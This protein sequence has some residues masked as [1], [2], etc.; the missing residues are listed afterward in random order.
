MSASEKKNGEMSFEDI[1]RRA[2]VTVLAAVKNSGVI[3]S[4]SLKVLIVTTGLLHVYK[5]ESKHDG[6]PKRYLITDE[7]VLTVFNCC[8]ESKNRHKLLIHGPNNYKLDIIFDNAY[9]QGRLIEALLG[10]GARINDPNSNLIY[11]EYLST[12]GATGGDDQLNLGKLTKPAKSNQ[13]LNETADKSSLKAISTQS[14][15]RTDNAY[16]VVVFGSA[17]FVENCSVSKEAR[18]N[19]MSSLDAL[20][21]TTFIDSLEDVGNQDEGIYSTTVRIDDW[22]GRLDRIESENPKVQG[23]VNDGDLNAEGKLT[24]KNI[25]HVDVTLPNVREGKVVEVDESLNG[26]SFESNDQG[27]IPH[28]E[29]N[30]GNDPVST[31]DVQKRGNEQGQECEYE[32][33]VADSNVDLSTGEEATQRKT[34]EMKAGEAGNDIGGVQETEYE[35]KD[36]GIYEQLW[37]SSTSSQPE[38]QI[39]NLSGVADEVCSGTMVCHDGILIDQQRQENDILRETGHSV[40]LANSNVVIEP[41]QHI[42]SEESTTQ[43]T[44][45][46]VNN[47]DLQKIGEAPENGHIIS[48]SGMHVQLFQHSN[49]VH[50]EQISDETFCSERK[51]QENDAQS[52]GLG[53]DALGTG[54]ISKVEFPQINFASHNDENIYETFQ[55]TPSNVGNSFADHVHSADDYVRENELEISDEKEKERENLDKNVKNGTEF[56]Q[57]ENP[58]EC[59]ATTNGIKS[60]SPN[61]EVDGV[62]NT[63]D[64]EVYSVLNHDCSSPKTSL[65]DSA[66]S[67]SGVQPCESAFCNSDKC[68]LLENKSLSNSKAATADDAA[69][70]SNDPILVNN[71]SLEEIIRPIKTLDQNRSSIVVIGIIEPKDSTDAESIYSDIKFMQSRAA[72]KAAAWNYDGRLNTEPIMPPEVNADLHSSNDSS[73]YKAG[74]IDAPPT[75]IEGISNLGENFVERSLELDLD[76][77]ISE[78]EHADL[79]S[80][81][82]KD[83]ALAQER[84]ITLETGSLEVADRDSS[85]SK[86]NQTTPSNNVTD[87]RRNT[88]EEGEK[89]G[90]TLN[91]ENHEIKAFTVAA[92]INDDVQSNLPHL[93]T[94]NPSDQLITTETIGETKQQASEASNSHLT[95]QAE[96]TVHQK[97]GNAEIFSSQSIYTLD[98]MEVETST[99]NASKR[100]EANAEIETNSRRYSTDLIDT[101]T[102][103][104]TE[105]F[106]SEMSPVITDVSVERVDSRSQSHEDEVSSLISNRAESQ[107]DLKTLHGLEDSGMETSTASSVNKSE[108]EFNKPAYALTGRNYREGNTFDNNNPSDKVFDLETCP[109]E[110]YYM[111]AGENKAAEEVGDLFIKIKNRIDDDDFINDEEWQTENEEEAFRGADASNASLIDVSGG[112]MQEETIGASDSSRTSGEKLSFEQ[113]MGKTLSSKKVRFNDDVQERLYAIS[114]DEGES[115]S[116]TDCEDEKPSEYLHQADIN[117]DDSVDNLYELN[118]SASESND[119]VQNDKDEY[120]D[121]EDSGESLSGPEELPVEIQD[122]ESSHNGIDIHKR[123]EKSCP[124]FAPSRIPTAIRTLNY[125]LRERRSLETKMK[126]ERNKASSEKSIIEQNLPNDLPIVNLHPEAQTSSNSQLSTVHCE[127]SG[128]CMVDVTGNGTKFFKRLI[129][130]D[131]GFL[132]VLPAKEHLQSDSELQ[133]SL[134][135]PNATSYRQQVVLDKISLKGASVQPGLHPSSSGLFNIVLQPALH[136]RINIQVPTRDEQMR[137]TLLLS[138]EVVR[139]TPEPERPKL[140]YPSKPTKLQPDV[141]KTPGPEDLIHKEESPSS[142]SRDTSD[143]ELCIPPDEFAVRELDFN[144]NRPLVLGTNSSTEQAIEGSEGNHCKRISIKEFALDSN[145]STT[146]LNSRVLKNSHTESNDT[147]S[148]SSVRSHETLQFDSLAPSLETE[149]SSQERPST[150][151]Q[152][153]PSFS[154]HFVVQQEEKY[155][156]KGFEYSSLKLKKNKQKAAVKKSNNGRDHSLTDAGKASK[157]RI[158]SF[159]GSKTSNSITDSKPQPTADRVHRNNSSRNSP[160]FGHVSAMKNIFENISTN[161]N[162][163][164]NT[165]HQ[166]KASLESSCKDSMA[167]SEAAHPAASPLSSALSHVPSKESTLNATAPQQREAGIRPSACAPATDASTLT[168]HNS[169]EVELNKEAVES[170]NQVKREVM[171]MKVAVAALRNERS[172]L[173]ERGDALCRQLASDSTGGLE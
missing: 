80:I 21:D 20:S 72:S 159:P 18:Y 5:R 46:E 165:G 26:T 90:S 153:S 164:R 71:S 129:R 137:L 74:R 29:T 113:I 36:S 154:T 84:T 108:D 62:L 98:K 155:I 127:N 96:D 88:P 17:N 102:R 11:A 140:L 160:F 144:V 172:Q 116:N 70:T 132:L 111:R 93:C 34:D 10:E 1:Q 125:N 85:K 16:D 14:R 99:Q 76:G 32:T 92:L 51:T 25:N 138:D 81:T 117:L 64:E 52:C 136:N 133:T 157:Q 19:K 128:L 110:D 141:L 89:K 131:A 28:E 115:T 122:N 30:P 151:N 49:S 3:R 94:N 7:T 54:N 103:K 45:E 44:T 118:S 146:T 121:V 23:E 105:T 65:G 123:E 134:V 40:T 59:S 107:Y 150:E 82:E 163:K 50:T 22:V 33:F 95:C 58:Q 169:S 156:E 27:K 173:V 31:S 38:E 66:Y 114:S 83:P 162:M 6:A 126:E 170:P 158:H 68:V 161:E 167:S 171:A 48:D 152:H 101:F 139:V 109:A 39:L 73:E 56:V 168:S 119:I 135:T 106:T 67:Q 63:I 15:E 43:K 57:H 86:G 60:S 53:S 13:G 91:P 149:K 47:S 2:T 41:E 147:E 12:K 143:A 87:E 100:K 124:S 77:R 8:P 142:R 35:A 4:R 24:E 75:E 37:L 120:S 69:C 145:I 104:F 97:T 166:R 9:N 112:R 130:I 61:E 55:L 78:N 42:S 79:S 148:T